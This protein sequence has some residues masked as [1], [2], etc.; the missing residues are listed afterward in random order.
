MIDRSLTVF[1]LADWLVEADLNRVSRAAK[2]VQLE[3]KTMDVLVLLAQCPG[4]VVSTDAII[5]VVWGGRPM[6]DNPVYKSIAKLRKAL[7]DDPTNPRF[8]ATVAK[9]GYRLLVEV[10][11]VTEDS[12][13][14]DAPPV[15]VTKPRR[16]L[17]VAIGMLIGV[18]AAAA[19]FWRPQPD[20]MSFQSISHF[21]GSH[22]QPSFAPDGSAIAF[23]SDISGES[24]IWILEF[25][26]S[27]PRQLT[28]GPR[29]DSRPRWSPDGSSVLF[30]RGDSLW[31]VPVAGGE[32][33]ELIRNA[34]NPNWSAD[35]Q[36]IVFERRFE[37]W[38]ADANGGQQTRVDG[39]PRRELPLAPRWP[40]FSPN[41]SE[42]VFLDATFTPLA[43]LWSV[44]L[45]GG[46]PVRLTFAP[47]F[48]SAPV[49]TPDG[50]SIIYSTQR[51]GSRT[52]WKVNINDKTSKPLLSGS[53][54]DD[55]P[56]VSADGR[57]LVYS[58][59]RE[60]FALL[61][62]DPDVGDERTVH[63]SRQMII[64]PELSPDRTTI[65]YFGFGRDGGVA[66]FTVPLSG[67]A[68]TQVTSEPLATHAIPRWSG[69]G[70]FLY[71]FHSRNASSFGKVTISNGE[72]A[73]LASGWD[74]NVANGASVSADGDQIV[75]SSLAGQVPVQTS[76]RNLQTRKVESFYAT[77]EYPRWS[78]D[79][80]NILGALHTDQSFPGDIAL[81]PV[82]GPPCRIIARDARIPMFSGDE[83]QVYFV[84]GY[85]ATQD[86]FVAPLAGGDEQKVMTMTPLFPLGPFYDVTPSGGILWVRYEQE[87]G[88]IW[89]SELEE[90]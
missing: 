26:E 21:E 45:G 49:W 57:R 89:L 70:R 86:L 9:K 58:N 68:P 55:F 72:F 66:L 90:L 2:S 6:G 42:I 34:Y 40:A 18:I 36:Q 67:E 20:P 29:V 62:H 32:P 28:H 33:A 31:T 47:S 8:I 19:V 76:I 82:A 13:L 54:D 25:D 4:D 27:V 87:S 14:P 79:G 24:H 50:K 7:G 81:C 64:A 48:A 43:D 65:A 60:R 37:I 63:E 39:V 16:F 15:P 83:T 12:K 46:T 71:S 1:Y 23:V 80:A 59:R 53:G 78:R 41:G 75:F 3:P 44:S 30:V 52:L 10:S 22:S 17:P 84:R 69:D 5:D 56:D 61:L 77:L 38:I 88:E 35:G 85:G 74:W 51:G 73:V 11:P